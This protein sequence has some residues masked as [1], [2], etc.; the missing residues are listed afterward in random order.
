M[1]N[2]P[3]VPCANRGCPNVVPGGGRCPDC[4][5]ISDKEYDHAWR[6]KKAAA[7]YQSKQW[8]VAR[9]NHLGVEPFCRGCRLDGGGLVPATVVDHIKPW[10]GNYD[11][12]LDPNN[13]Q[14]LCDHCHA[15]KSVKER[16][17]IA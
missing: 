4:K 1:P 15:V 14:S 10:A 9:L 12:A 17:D 5:K 2:L 13:L 11:L 6:D 8:K 7:F 16:M 3:G